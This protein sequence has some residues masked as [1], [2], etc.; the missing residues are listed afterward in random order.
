MRYANV[1]LMKAEALNEQGTASGRTEAINLINEIR[2]VHGKLPPMEGDSYEAVKAQIEHERLVEFSVE[3]FRFYDLRRWGKLEEAMKADGRT[4][5][6]IAED[7]FLPIP[8]MEIQ[9]NNDVN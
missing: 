1:M 2:E 7:E 9:T 8:L 3:C 6:N 4:N 5:F